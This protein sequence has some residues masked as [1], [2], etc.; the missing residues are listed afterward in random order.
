MKKVIA[1]LLAVIVALAMPACGKKAA[2]KSHDAMITGAVEE[3]KN[4]WKENY[5]TDIANGAET[6]KYFQIIN[7]RVLTIS[8]NDFSDFLEVSHIIEFEILSDYLGTSPYYQNAKV[9]NNVVV[10]QDGHMEVGSNVLKTSQ[11]KMANVN[12]YGIIEKI[13][14]YQGQ[15]NWSGKL[16]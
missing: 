16:Q 12:V 6:D 9:F 1:M 13:D 5:D 10:Y 11:D 14:D 3:L 2:D 7:T 4:T 15:Y 8:I